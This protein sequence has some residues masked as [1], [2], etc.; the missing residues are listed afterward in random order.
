MKVPKSLRL[1]KAAVV[2]AV[3]GVSAATLAGCS[4]DGSSAS[5]ATSTATSELNESATATGPTEPAVSTENQGVP[6]SANEEAALSDRDVITAFTEPASSLDQLRLSDQDQELIYETWQELMA[7]CM[8]QRGFDMVVM[9]YAATA[10]SRLAINVPVLEADIAAFG[11]HLLPAA[12][13]QPDLPNERRMQVDIP[14]RDALTGGSD[15]DNADGCIDIS[16]RETYDDDGE[17]TQ[18][19]QQLGQAQADLETRILES[20][21][22]NNLDARWAACMRSAGYEYA[23]PSEPLNRFAV[24]TS[25][26]PLEVETRRRDVAC[27]LDLDY[28]QSKHQLLEALVTSWI[29]DHAQE[30]D[31]YNSLKTDYMRNITEVRERLALD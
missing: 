27:Q 26:T 16:R 10:G 17:F 29:D 20:E 6:T 25:V 1:I 8:E 28:V 22:M 7:D 30:I 13:T 19:D 4:H 11:Y 14:F 15:E 9:P 12:S 5:A 18:L 21:E 23:N 2:A 31:H 24:A 3:V